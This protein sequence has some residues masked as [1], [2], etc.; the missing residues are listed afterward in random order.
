MHDT[1]SRAGNAADPPYLSPDYMSTR[2]AVAEAAADHHPADA[3]GDHRARSTATPTS[4]PRRPTSP[5]ST[6]ASRWASASSS[7]AACSTRTAG[8]CPTRWSRSGS[9]TPPAATSTRSTSTPRRSI[10]TSP[11]PAARH[12]RRRPLPVHHHQA[13]RLSLAQPPQ[14]L[15]PGAH[16][17]LAVRPVVPDAARHADVL[18]RRPAV[19]V[20][21]D[22]Q[23]GAPTPRRA[24]AWS[25]ASTWRRP[26]PSGRW[27]TS[28][29]SCCAASN[30]TPDGSRP[31][32]S[33]RPPR[34]SAPTCTSASRR[35]PTACARSSARSSPIPA[36]PAP[37]SAS[38]AA[39]STARATSLPDALVEIWQADRQG[40]YAHP[41][42]GRPLASNSFRGF[43]R[44]ADRQG[45]RLRLRHR[46]ARRA[47]PAPAARTQ[48]PHINVGVFARGL[49][50]APV[51]AHLLRRRSGQRGRSDPGAGAGRPPRHADRQARPGQARPLPLRHPP[52]GRRTRPCSSTRRRRRK[53]A[54]RSGSD[55][56]PLHLPTCQS[57]RSGTAGM[58]TLGRGFR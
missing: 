31:C 7:R 58:P 49:L 55:R 46:Q 10:P 3:V 41:A 23:L 52:A 32:L 17:L 28:S 42:D 53:R 48:A 12:R 57:A 47:C 35:A 19:P 25:A 27:A 26:S 22:L 38:R 4:S 54:P 40:R 36:C 5:R 45:R 13:R 8:R 56:H 1:Y 43:G 44:C 30:A 9:A 37:T 2:P 14:R 15:A 39:S 20:R 50:E 18:P 6:P 16:P 11:A 34:P 24:S 29:T 33:A 51:H 21:P